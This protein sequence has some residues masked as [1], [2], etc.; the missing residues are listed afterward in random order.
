MRKTLLTACLLI[1]SATQAQVL[2]VNNANGTYQA[3][4]TKTTKNITFDEE[5]K[6][7]HI[8]LGS[9]NSN[10][11][12]VSSFNTAKATNIAPASNQGT[13]LTYDL[14]P[15]VA[16]D[17]KDES[18][19]NEIVETIITDETI[20]ESGDFVENFNTNRIITITFSENGV[21]TSTLPDQVTTTIENGHITINSERSKVGYRVTGTCSNG[22]LKIY[23]LKKFQIMTQNL[24]LTNP[25]GPAINIQSGKTVYFTMLT[26]TNNTLCDG[27]TYGAA[28][29]GTDGIEED[30]KGTLFSEGQI[31][32]NGLGTL[33][34]KSLGGHAIASDD[35]IRIRSG[36]INIVEAAKDGFHTKDKFILSR[37]EASAPTVSIKATSN[38]ID[39]REGHI[40][41]EAGKMTIE[42]GS[43]AIKAVYEEPIPDPLVSPDTYI[44]G[45]FVKIVTTDEKSSAIKTTRNYIQKGGVIH[46]DV[47]GNG[48]KIINCDNEVTIAGG[49]LTGFSRGTIA[50]DT[51]S[52]GG[53]KSE[54]VLKM[55]G[56]IIA[57]ECS[58]KGAKGINSNSDVI[59]EGGEITLLTK[60]AN[61]TDIA[62][63]KKSRGIIANSVTVN[64][65]KIVASAYNNAITATTITV[66]DGI[67][68]AYSESSY[69]LGTDA[70][71]T[72]G[73][74]LTKD[75]E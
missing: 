13:E 19:Y 74:L 41:I 50:T 69:A 31:I 39:C 16:F 63:D 66:N 35:Y 58:G 40:T 32:F 15:V 68:N 29:I 73:W 42:S 55:T 36:N 37:T 38:G 20:D 10:E 26:G 33:N 49:K 51:T 57:I 27:A 14:N 6:L 56:G 54:N 5:Q 65:G 48:S 9:V 70:V 43:E 75:N 24:N 60:A 47:K 11:T 18:N 71:Q 61:Y 1:A 7:V 44:N 17:T 22:S 12:I 59:I 46:A 34:V 21:K 64:G 53:I 28:T 52:A 30:Q 3:F 72:G 8:Q 2:Y 23:S 4:D 67:V 62:D 25:K 45:G